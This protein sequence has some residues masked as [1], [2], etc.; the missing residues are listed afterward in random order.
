MKA[1]NNGGLRAVLNYVHRSKLCTHGDNLTLG[2]ADSPEQQA[3][4]TTFRPREV[5]GPPMEV[6]V[7]PTLTARDQTF[8][9]TQNELTSSFSRES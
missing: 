4:T 2:N 3:C 5:V 8:N 6:V 1:K 7:C 9:Y